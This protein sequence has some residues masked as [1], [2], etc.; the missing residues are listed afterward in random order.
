VIP[1][2]LG[3]GEGAGLRRLRVADLDGDGRGEAILTGSAGPERGVVVVV[4]VH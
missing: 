1:I 3:G 4:R 2:D